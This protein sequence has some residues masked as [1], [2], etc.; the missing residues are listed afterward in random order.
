MKTLQG[1]HLDVAIDEQ[2]LTVEVRDRRN[3]VWA[4]AATSGPTRA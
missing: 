3:G 1:K 2:T 4:C